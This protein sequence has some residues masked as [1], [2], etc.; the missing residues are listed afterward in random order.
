[1]TIVPFTRG[2]LRDFISLHDAMDRLFEESVVPSA[3]TSGNG[4]ALAL[5]VDIYEEN[6]TY[7]VK[8]A[9]PPGV[10]PEDVQIEA[11]SNTLTISGETR[12]EEEANEGS[13]VRRELRYG[14]FYRILELPTELDPEKAEASFESGTLT[15]RIPKSAATK[16]KQI[17]VQSANGNTS[18]RDKPSSTNG[19]T[20]AESAKPSAESTKAPVESARSTSERA[21][22]QSGT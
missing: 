9:L 1:M 3:G 4:G 10:N 16:P 7:V 22:A 14:R 17:K 13:Y 2:V 11:T 12:R 19:K 21:K 15:V 20:S 8:A 5:P 6:D 18:D